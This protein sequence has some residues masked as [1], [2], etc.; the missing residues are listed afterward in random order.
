MLEE[1]TGNL[2]ITSST[3]EKLDKFNNTRPENT[4]ATMKKKQTKKKHL[5]GQI[6]SN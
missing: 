6:W 1:K 5:H 4:G 2:Q 3:Q